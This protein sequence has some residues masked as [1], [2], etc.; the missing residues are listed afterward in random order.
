MPFR[1]RDA[2]SIRNISELKASDKGGMILQPETGVYAR[3]PGYLEVAILLS[4][5]SSIDVK[6]TDLIGNEK[7]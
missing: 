4:V 7:I 1:N 6:R 3:Q 2:E 5:Y